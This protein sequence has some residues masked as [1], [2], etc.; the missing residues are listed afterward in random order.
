M[1][2]DRFMVRSK[3]TAIRGTPSVRDIKLNLRLLRLRSGQTSNFAII[4]STA[5]GEIQAD[6]TKDV[7]D[8][9][10]APLPK[11]STKPSCPRDNRK[12]RSANPPLN[13]TYH[14]VLSPLPHTGSLHVR[15]T[16][17]TKTTMNVQVILAPMTVLVFTGCS[18]FPQRNVRFSSHDQADGKSIVFSYPSELRA[19]TIVKIAKPASAE[20]IAVLRQSAEQIESLSKEL[21]SKQNDP[22][23]LRRKAVLEDQLNR[24]MSLVFRTA[25]LAEPPPDTVVNLSKITFAPKVTNPAGVGGD[26]N[27]EASQQVMKIDIS[28]E[29]NIKRHMAY[30]LNEAML[31]FPEVV[32]PIYGALFTKI[33]EHKTGNSSGGV[34]VQKP[35]APKEKE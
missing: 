16:T 4:P 35:A 18:L 7:S 29:A 11:P 20:E 13:P 28:D 33:L 19:S 27:L 8:L 26:L 3:T 9:T 1:V 31:N 21:D 14:S 2:A 22:E 17:N 15:Q 34:D 25:I 30:R 6:D 10:E 12:P 23:L 24:Q 32:G 5:S